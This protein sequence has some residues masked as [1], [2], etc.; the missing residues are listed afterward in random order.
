MASVDLDDLIRLAKLRANAARQ[1]VASAEAALV[2][3]NFAVAEASRQ[4]ALRDLRGKR[5]LGVQMQQ[6]LSRNSPALKVAQVT[7]LYET[8]EEALLALARSID[9][10]RQEAMSAEGR[11][12]QARRAAV[13]TE[14]R[15]A[16]L[17]EAHERGSKQRRID[18]ERRLANADEH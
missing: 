6:L 12:I 15:L 9:G 5:E 11:L 13:E 7:A 3:A 2:E 17:E 18:Q 16:K 4:F 14:R 8:E 10:L 1:R